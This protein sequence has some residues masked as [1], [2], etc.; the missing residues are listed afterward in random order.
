MS[1]P[2]SEYRCTACRYQSF[3]TVLWGRFV[4]ELGSEQLSV[5]RRLGWCL[6][7]AGLVPIEA[8][9]DASTIDEL[10]ARVERPKK[11][12]RFRE[13]RRCELNPGSA[14]SFAVSPRCQLWFALEPRARSAT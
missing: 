6:A 1:M 2:A 4:Y 7:C 12:F 8:F 11:T 10:Q 9:L 14:G 5:P 3:S 13:L